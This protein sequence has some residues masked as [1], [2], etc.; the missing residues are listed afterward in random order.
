MKRFYLSF[1]LCVLLLVSLATLA[2][3]TPAPVSVEV[4][5]VDSRFFPEMRVTL[6]VADN[7]NGRLFE[8]TVANLSATYNGQPME[9]LRV[10]SSPRD[11]ALH[12]SILLDLTTS[13]QG[14]QFLQEQKTTVDTLISKLRPR[15]SVAI[16]TFSGRTAQIL[17][18]LTEDHNAALNAVDALKIPNESNNVFLDGMARA[19]EALEASTDP[20]AR[21]AVIV[22]TDTNNALGSAS[23]SDIIAKARALQAPIYIIGFNDADRA[24]LERFSA[25]TKGYTYILR[26][27]I[28][29]RSL[30][31]LTQNLATLLTGENVVVLRASSPA[32]NAQGPLVIAAQVGA[33]RGESEPRLVAATSRAIK[34]TFPNLPTTPVSNTVRLEPV[35]VYADNDAP[36][37]IVK[38][39][40]YV[41]T[42]IAA[43]QSGVLAPPD[44]ANPVYVWD[45]KEL[46]GG[47]YVLRLEVEDEVGNRAQQ[48]F[49]VTVASPLTVTITNPVNTADGSIPLIPSGTVTIVAEVIS[50]FGID[51]V[52]LLVNGKESG[53]LT[54]N[55][56]PFEFELDSSKFSAGQYTLR[57]EAT[58]VQNSTAFDE[59][60][61][62]IS[63]PSQD[64][65]VVMLALIVILVALFVFILIA[66]IL[67]RRNLQNQ[68]IAVADPAAPIPNE[69]K[70][71][72]QLAVINGRA[73]QPLYQLE[74]TQYRVG[75]A[76]DN[77]IRVDS[78]RASRFHALIE[79]D[80]QTGQF[81]YRDLSPEKPNRTLINN[82][83]LQGQHRLRSGDRIRVGDT[84]FEFRQ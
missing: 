10:E 63:I 26:E 31:T 42:G 16:T 12:F 75:R 60:L 11:S 38:A 41:E 64:V 62:Q 48:T 54:K 51:K 61:V 7:Q 19:V 32:N 53:K 43:N 77:Q 33:A 23:E 15:D 25:P 72:A 30:T 34:I 27:Q 84:E 57:V 29:G 83:P 49:T 45:I 35:I 70:I 52:R 69:P 24:L 80:V 37:K 74:A 8:P 17:V 59:Q 67:R 18:P 58:D 76:R 79:I 14:T 4:F 65:P 22:L 5:N 9:V 39:A 66:V 81:L 1:S 36:T 40:Y 21:R 68:S 6:R 20:N 44:T 28:Q 50:D 46:S 73:N 55:T 71:L 3:T 47:N 13:Q 82:I 78:D 2:Q 56:S